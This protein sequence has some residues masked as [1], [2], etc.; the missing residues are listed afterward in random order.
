MPRFNLSEKQILDL[1]SRDLVYKKGITYYFSGRVSDFLFAPT[2]S[3]V[4]ATVAGSLNRYAVQITFDQNSSVCAYH[5]SCQAYEEYPKACKHIIAVLKAAQDKLPAI[6]PDPLVQKRAVEELLTVFANHRSEPSVEELTLEVE[7]HIHTGHRPSAQLQL[8]LGLQRLYVVK[9]ISQFLSSIK[10][11]QSLE[12][13]KQFTFE[14]TRQIFKEQDRAVIS[15]LQEMHE[16]LSAFSEMQ[17][18][19]FSS[20]LLRQK[21]LPMIGY[22]LNKLLDAL[23]EKVFHLKF[24]SAPL[25]PSQIIRKGLPIEFSLQ[26]QDLDLTLALES[27][28]L[29]LQLTSDSSYY[30]YQQKIHMASPT[31][32]DL[33]PAMLR[34]LKKGSMTNIVVPAGQ[35]EFFASEALPLI[36]KLGQVFIDP[37]LADKF[38]QESLLAKIY[39]D[40]VG[41]SSTARLEFH[42]GDTVINPFAAT[43]ETLNASGA[44][45][46]ILI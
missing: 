27:N 34:A 10:T 4:N 33:L 2:K 18:F 21:V 41:E 19:Y 45:D 23:G 9:D 20:T 32:K 40:R 22:Y 7:L 25:Q 35:K 29:P 8:K 11:G 38:N 5:C 39:F 17:S 6:W 42:Y 30:T 31:Q 1:A 28:E 24:D 16:Q 43:R 12:F 44:N 3:M 15:L 14:P 13:G 26:A 36:N 37:S 46:L